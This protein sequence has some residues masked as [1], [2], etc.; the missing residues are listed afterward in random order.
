MCEEM[1][2]RK[3]TWQEL[4]E[5]YRQMV[6]NKSDTLVD[7]K[8]FWVEETIKEIFAYYGGLTDRQRDI[9]VIVYTGGDDIA[10]HWEWKGAWA[11]LNSIEY[12]DLARLA[13]THCGNPACSREFTPQEVMKGTNVVYG[14]RF[15]GDSRYGHVL[16]CLECAN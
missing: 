2:G 13:Q 4:W 16:F 9:Y 12:K 11:F 15:N 7:E 6:T 14:G 1:K 8:T 5:F 3:I 10:Y